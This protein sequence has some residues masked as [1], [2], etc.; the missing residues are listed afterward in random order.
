[1][2]LFIS[3]ALAA[4]VM[5]VGW[6]D[7]RVLLPLAPYLIKFIRCIPEQGRAALA[8]GTEDDERRATI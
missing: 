6:H 5:L 4:V 8:A 7:A 2:K 3:A 1:M